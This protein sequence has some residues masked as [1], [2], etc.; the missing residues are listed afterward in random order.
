MK[1]EKFNLKAQEVLT[2]AGNLAVKND[3]SYATP[4]HLMLGLIENSEVERYLALADA[5]MEVLNNRL[6]KR[7][8]GFPK[9]PGGQDTSIDRETEKILILAEEA[10]SNLGD[11][12]ISVNHLLIGMLEDPIIGE[13]L[14]AAGIDKNNFRQILETVKTGKFKGESPADF[15]FLNKFATDLT[16]KA[17]EGKLDPVIGRDAEIRQTI[18][19][20]SRRLKNN[21]I[22]IGEPGVG[23]TAIIE[24]LAQKIVAREVPEH[25]CDHAIFALDLGAL[26]AGTKFRGEFEERFKNVIQEASIAE[27]VILFIDE[28]HMI[29]GAGGIEGSMDASNLLKPALSRGEIRCIGSTTLNEYRK[30]I[31]KDAALTR[32][33]QKIL[34]EEPSVEQA[35]SILRGLK[36]KYEVHHGVRILDATIHASVN[37]SHRYITDRFLPDKAIDLLDETAS[38]IRMDI[39]SKP[40]EIEE[41]D[42]AIIQ[43]EIEL[44]ALEKEQDE[45][46]LAR[47]KNLPQELAELKAHSQELT[48]IWQKEKKAIYEAQQAKQD[49]ESAKLEMEQRIREEDFN[50]VAELQYKIIPDREKTLAQYADIDISSPRFLHEA[51]REEDVASTVSRWTG[52]PVHKMMETEKERLLKMEE[53]LHQRVIGQD[54]AVSAVAKAIRRSRAGLQDPLPTNCL[55]FDAW[56]DWC[57]K[58]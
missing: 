50:R 36:E 13:D 46:S 4:T 57:R 18:Q 19:V 28:I 38:S 10:A 26:V 24:G 1:I 58:N 11:K 16:E 53:L 29:I 30:H 40:E 39:A 34:T 8:A 2:N 14:V 6:K 31:E 52:I 3:H 20:L 7:L 25:L 22:I 45:T 5:T 41:I 54:D 23:K 51:V 15:E 47:L 49:L 56:P 33:F 9:E 43:K 27:N 42:R 12:Y 35:I 32:R 48:D 17:R 44:K 21:P 37:F 55:I